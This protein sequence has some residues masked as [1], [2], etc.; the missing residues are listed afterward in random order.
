M[1]SIVGGVLTIGVLVALI[2]WVVSGPLRLTPFNFA[3]ARTWFR[4]PTGQNAASVL[5]SVGLAKLVFDIG[6]RIPANRPTSALVVAAFALALVFSLA[7]AERRAGFLLSVVGIGAATL[8]VM[9]DFGLPG[10]LA[11]LALTMV[12]VWILGAIRGFVSA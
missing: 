4:M 1:R 10:A 5:A 11:L 3:R 8:G 2:R 9:L 7:V 12:L 6:R